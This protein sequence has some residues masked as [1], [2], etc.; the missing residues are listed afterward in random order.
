MKDIIITG[1]S[2]GIGRALA[3]SLATG[4]SDPAR[5]ILTA[6]DE[7]LLY[8]VVQ[9]IETAGGHAHCVP[10]DLSTLASARTLGE[11]L[12]SVVRTPATLVHNAGVWPARRELTPEGLETAFVVNCV[13][14]LLMQQIL[15]DRLLLDRVMVIS[16]G[17]IVKG[18]YSGERT[19]TGMDFSSWRTYCTTKLAFAVAERDMAKQHPDIDFVVLHPGVVRTNLGARR[20]IAGILLGWVKWSLESPDVCANRLRDILFRDCWSPPGDARWLVKERE[21]PWPSVTED[22]QTR[23]AIREMVSRLVI[24]AEDETK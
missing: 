10:G 22:E 11:N 21:K 7:V 8:D 5:L 23:R 14:P 15:L 3:V 24:H 6:R 2:R 16:A 4:A 17:L 9:C 12:A 19:P 1:A 13:G 18:R 20:G